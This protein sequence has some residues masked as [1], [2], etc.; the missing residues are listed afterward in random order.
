M[1]I[2]IDFGTSYSAAGVLVDDR[3]EL[4]AFGQEKQFR[5]T[6]YFRQPVPDPGL[7][8]LTPALEAEVDSL[9][10]ASRNQQARR[11]SRASALREQAA[12][13]PKAIREEQLRL[14]PE[15]QPRTE[16]QMRSE[17]VGAARAPRREVAP[18]GHHRVTAQHD[19]APRAARRHDAQP[20]RHAVGGHRLELLGRARGDQK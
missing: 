8:A 2:G 7:F 19:P 11:I 6:A 1:R 9:V 4:L 15:V 10:R 5:T 13:A 18:V 12:R 14:V 16:A 20:Q 3:V 17:A